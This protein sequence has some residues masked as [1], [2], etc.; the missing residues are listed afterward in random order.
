MQITAQFLDVGGEVVRV[1]LVGP[2]RIA[3]RRGESEG[4]TD[5]Q[6]DPS[7]CI[8]SSIANCSAT[9]IG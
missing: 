1:G 8:A 7:G 4:T 2:Q 6:I 9:T 5:T 3:H